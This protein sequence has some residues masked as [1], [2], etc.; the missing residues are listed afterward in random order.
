MG[1]GDKPI[2]IYQNLKKKKK[3]SGVLLCSKNHF[4]RTK[5][6]CFYC[7]YELFPSCNFSE[8]D[9]GRKMVLAGIKVGLI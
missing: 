2:V 9:E 3:P 1:F 7:C 8:P 6:W 4:K 5:L